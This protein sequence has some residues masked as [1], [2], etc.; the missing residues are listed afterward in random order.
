MADPALVPRRGTAGPRYAGVAINMFTVY[1]LKS[2]KNRR[3]YIGHTHDIIQR[4]LRHNQGRVKSTKYGAPWKIMLTEEYN[5]KS[6]ATRRELEI[7]GYKSGIK[8]KNLIGL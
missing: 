7:K 3:Y 5:S 2:I 1:I 4:I 6:L 8:F